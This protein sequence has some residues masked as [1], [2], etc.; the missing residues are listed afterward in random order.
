MNEIVKCI[1]GAA[2]LAI[3]AKLLTF[4]EPYKIA[5]IK[6]VVAFAEVKYA[7][8][9]KSGK[10]KKAFALSIL[11]WL[12]IQADDTTSDIIDAIVSVAND[13]SGE[14]VST[15]KTVTTTEVAAKLD[16]IKNSVSK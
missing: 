7:D 1:V 4:I 5:L 13:K 16:E 2:A 12:L 15:V 3:L 10:Q 6:R 9:E 8:A 14:I 11:K